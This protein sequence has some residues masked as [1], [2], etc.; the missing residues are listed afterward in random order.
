MRPPFPKDPVRGSRE[1]DDQE[2][3]E[4]LDSMFI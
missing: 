3:V 2:I 4:A 1:I